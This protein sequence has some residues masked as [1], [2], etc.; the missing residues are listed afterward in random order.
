M[1]RDLFAVLG[2]HAEWF[3]QRFGATEA[4]YFI[5]P[6]GSPLPNDPERPSVELKTAWE[7]IRTAARVECRWHD[8]RHTV[9]TKLAEAGVPESTMLAIMG[10]M[11]RAM[12]ERYSHVRM[13]AKRNAVEA[14]HLEPASTDGLPTKSPTIA[15]AP[16]V[17]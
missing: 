10:H 4:R 7:S 12:L 5:F 9:C 1:N 15:V 13:A 11:S 14:L 2:S 3:T 6:H 16:K 8:L 17:N